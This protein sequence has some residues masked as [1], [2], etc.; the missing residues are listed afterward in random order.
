M[1][2]VSPCES[3]DWA[4]REA[5]SCTKVLPQLFA[6]LLLGTSLSCSKQEPENLLTKLNKHTT[7]EQQNNA[8]R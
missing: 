2:S 5:T 4:P 3:A 6:S 1:P 7:S 8:I